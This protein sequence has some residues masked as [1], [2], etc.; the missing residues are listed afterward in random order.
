M[1]QHPKC[2]KCKAK[3]QRHGTM[4][5]VGLTVRCPKCRKLYRANAFQK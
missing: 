3:L 5:G 1:K 2:P 4:Y